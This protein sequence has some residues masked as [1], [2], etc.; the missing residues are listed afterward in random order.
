MVLNACVVVSSAVCFFWC[1]Q[2][3]IYHVCVRVCTLLHV[4]QGLQQGFGRVA[5]SVCIAV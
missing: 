5:L 3:F 2:S 1:K 4:H